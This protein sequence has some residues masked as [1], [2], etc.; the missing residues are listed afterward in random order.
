MQQPASSDARSVRGI[1]LLPASIAAVVLVADQ[2]TKYWAFNT[3]GPEEGS[4]VIPVIGD[5]F[6]FVFLKNTGIAFGLGQ[7]LS[8]LFIIT[9]LLIT[10][11][12]IYF[13]RYHLPHGS[14][15]VQV[16]IGLIVGGAIGNIIDRVR[17]SY[18]I[19]FISIGW[20]PIFNIADS[21]ISVGVTLLA[22]YLLFT[23]GEQPQQT[24]PQT[25]AYDD[26]L[27]N[28]LLSRETWKDR[29]NS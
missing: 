12:A 13:Y 22:I 25:P 5:W 14:R 1:W 18:V 29:S 27:L 6:R 8:N 16:T 21:A 3:L 20:W 9:S 28:D 23:D 19:D 17:L 2:I 15:W 10:A 24:A 7:N 4:V 11:G 26:P